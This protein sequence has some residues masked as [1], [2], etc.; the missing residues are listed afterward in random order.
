M[1]Q[2]MSDLE[3]RVRLRLR[4]EMAKKHLSQRDVS[5]ILGGPDKGWSQSRVS[6]ILNGHVEMG[7]SDMEGLCFALS[8]PIV[9]VV[10][11]L[12]MEFFAEM[13]PTELRTLERIRQ[14]SDPDREAYLHLL[15][16]KVSA[17]RHAT[18]SPSAAQRKR[19]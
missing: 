13:T 11:D 16:V 3:E 6:K 9:E 17:R 5:G 12:G 10:R 14:L 18:P 7:V 1:V 15:A 8:V 19:R 2:L 4:E